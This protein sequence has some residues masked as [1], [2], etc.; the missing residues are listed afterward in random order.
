MHHHDVLGATFGQE[1]AECTL[2]APRLAVVDDDHGCGT[3]VEEGAHA[4][5]E[6]RTGI[7]IDDD[8]GN[9]ARHCRLNTPWRSGSARVPP[10]Q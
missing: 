10:G 4:L 1:R 6:Q 3:V 9:G 7:V 2:G 5:G 8:G